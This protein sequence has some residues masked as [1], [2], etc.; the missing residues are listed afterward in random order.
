[1]KFRNLLINR[2]G[3]ISFPVFIIVTL[4]LL[5]AV[6]HIFNLTS[7]QHVS[8]DPGQKPC[9]AYS[10]N[11]CPSDSCFKAEHDNNQVDFQ[12]DDISKMGV[13]CQAGIHCY[14]GSTCVRGGVGLLCEPCGDIKETS[15][16]N[17]SVGCY[18]HK[19]DNGVD[20][21]CVYGT[22]E[23]SCGA[24]NYCNSDEA[25]IS[26][27][28][29][30][31]HVC[32]KKGSQTDGESCTKQI[33]S[34][35][36]I[37][38][39]CSSDT[40]CIK[41]SDNKFIC[42]Y[43]AGEFCGAGVY[44]QTT[45][46][47][48]NESVNSSHLKCVQKGT[49]N[50]GAYCGYNKAD[51]KAKDSACSSGKC[52]TPSYTCASGGSNGTQPQQPPAKPYPGKGYCAKNSPGNV[53]AD[54]RW[55]ADPAHP[56]E[57]ISCNFSQTFYKNDSS[58]NEYC[59]QHT[60]ADH[61]YF[62][63]CP[64]SNPGNGGIVPVVI[65][66]D[67]GGVDGSQYPNGYVA[68]ICMASSTTPSKENFR[69]GVYDSQK[70]S[71]KKYKDGKYHD[72]YVCQNGDYDFI[73]FSSSTKCSQPPW[74]PDGSQQAANCPAEKPVF[75]GVKCVI[76]PD[77][78]P[79]VGPNGKTNQCVAASSKSQYPAPDTHYPNV[80][81]Q[82]CTE[83][84]NGLGESGNFA[85]VG[86]QQ[87]NPPP[88]A[89]PNP[90]SN[91]GSNPPPS[92]NGTETEYGHCYH[93]DQDCAQEYKCNNPSGGASAYCIYKNPSEPG[94]YCQSASNHCEKA[95]ACARGSQSGL[96]MGDTYSCQR[97]FGTGY[98][99]CTGQ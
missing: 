25:C 56:N 36:A 76:P 63:P 84:K 37:P 21:K 77:S 17:A 42:Q 97:A 28:Y 66:K 15:L 34:P 1:M 47:C 8:S 81:D 71:Q 92:N 98:I 12:C 91:P 60:D 64:A 23:E 48:V 55:I 24:G 38:S 39:A 94:A 27:G 74:T 46:T 30:G 72:A 19:S 22:K 40:Q 20:D 29:N 95:T 4:L 50:P 18:W 6:Q 31:K 70:A 61:A 7:K 93:G 2:K 88:Q 90:G 69:D 73:A 67:K 9:S 85:C 10:V 52:N 83:H 87:G 58:A 44:C 51:L 5:P 89:N 11:T 65:C 49:L 57:P 41:T 68:G 53:N 13:E 86:T 45:E 99:C 59:H 54:P 35:I 16:C 3:F 78:C 79:Q 62:Y 33:A 14:S 75:D 82:A 96:R 32:V 43:T 80:A 26:R